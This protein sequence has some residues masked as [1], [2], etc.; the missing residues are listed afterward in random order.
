MVLRTTGGTNIDGMK[1]GERGGG[2]GETVQRTLSQIHT[3]TLADSNALKAKGPV[4]YVS[5]VQRGKKAVQR[6]GRFAP[7]RKTKGLDCAYN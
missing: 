1:I 5:S 2:R 7:A 4:C 3:H 6:R